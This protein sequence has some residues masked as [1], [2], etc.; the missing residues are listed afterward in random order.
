[1]Q[2]LLQAKRSSVNTL[3]R[4]VMQFQHKNRLSLQC[5]HFLRYLQHHYLVALLSLAASR[6]KNQNV[7]TQRLYGIPLNCNLRQLMFVGAALLNS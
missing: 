5:L 4:L 2:L 1:M 3:S 7:E 6:K